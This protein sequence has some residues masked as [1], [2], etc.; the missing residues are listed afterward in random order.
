MW[1]DK[2]AVTVVEV[3]DASWCLDLVVE[4][5]KTRALVIFFLDS[6]VFGCP[7]KEYEA[8]KRP[9]MKKDPSLDAS[10]RVRQ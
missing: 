7:K 5:R 1:A 3:M 2:G 8:C 10:S 4:R 6:R 9:R